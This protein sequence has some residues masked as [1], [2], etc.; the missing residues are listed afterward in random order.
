MFGDISV[1]SEAR[2][3]I[4][5]LGSTA[6][7]GT[8]GRGE[9]CMETQ[10]SARRNLAYNPAKTSVLLQVSQLAHLNLDL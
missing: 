6:W 8:E 7:L 1:M 3:R 5:V 2:G 9:S 4:L 10:N